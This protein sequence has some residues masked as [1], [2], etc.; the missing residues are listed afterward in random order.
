MGETDLQHSFIQEWLK[1]KRGEES[2]NQTIIDAIEKSLG[3]LMNQELDES[4]L[5]KLLQE[6]KTE[7][8]ND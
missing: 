6:I 2:F 7:R 5:L 3:G 1:M 8:K 4:N